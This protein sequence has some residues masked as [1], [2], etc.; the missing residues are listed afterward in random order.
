M[1]NLFFFTLIILLGIYVFKD[2]TKPLFDIENNSTTTNSNKRK[3]YLSG[4]NSFDDEYV[5]GAKKIIEDNFNFN[6]VIKKSVSIGYSENNFDCD[7]AQT[8]LGFSPNKYCDYDEPVTV[9][10]T[11][12][13]IHSLG[14]KV[15]GVCY[16]NQIYVEQYHGFKETVVHELCHSIGMS[17][18]ENECI[19]NSNAKCRW[20][21]KLNKPIYCKYCKSK[22]P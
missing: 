11:N 4:F 17:H 22:L 19:M 21:K 5:K 15:R 7:L 6:C 10:I 13:N 9:F 12:E 1:K 8:K 3:V 16:G 2:D 20:N 18:C 14:K